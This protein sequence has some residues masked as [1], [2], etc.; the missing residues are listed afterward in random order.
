M[1]IFS[2]KSIIAIGFATIIGL[3]IALMAVWTQNVADNNRHLRKLVTKQAESRLVSMLQNRAKDR[4]ISI[5]RMTSLEDPFELEDEIT[6]FRELGSDFIKAREQLLNQLHTPL[7]ESAWHEVQPFIARGGQIQNKTVELILD[8]NLD[9]AQQLVWRELIPNQDQVMSRLENMVNLQRNSAENDLAQY[10]Q[11]NQHTYILVVFLASVAVLLGLFT[12]F[13]VRRTGK[14]EEAL[15]AQGRRIRALYEVTS[16]PGLSNEEQ[17]LE[18]LRLGSRLLN[19]SSANVTRIEAESDMAQVL[20]AVAPRDYPIQP[21]MSIPLAQS[22]AGKAF[23]L[24]KTI[25]FEDISKTEF[26]KSPT[27]HQ[28][29]MTAYL[30]APIM[31]RNRHIGVISFCSTQVRKKNFEE[32]DKDIA[33]LIAGWVGVAM[34]RDMSQQELQQAKDEAET[35]NLTKSAFLANMSHELRTPLNAIIGYSELMMDEAREEDRQQDATDLGHI[36]NSGTHLL[37]LINGVLD[38]SKI[39]AGK[40][41]LNLEHFRL[42]ELIT[43]VVQTAT[44]LMQKNDNRFEYHNNCTIDIVHSDRLKL[45]QI[46]LNL[47]SNAAKFTHQGNVSMTLSNRFINGIPWLSVK[48]RDTGIGMTDQ[49]VK[50]VFNSFTQANAMISTRYGGTGLGLSISK[51]MSL[52]LGGTMQAHSEIDHGSIFELNLPVQHDRYNVVPIERPLRA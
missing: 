6:H 5:Y 22:P 1:S 44:P 8:G 36:H 28:F 30:G 7:A 24:C 35:A 11:Q 16:L 19:M 18:M 34:E 9:A 2:S 14:T 17:I 27:H 13:V 52:I 20:F 38:L 31:V 23:H 12:I 10:A 50:Q 45:M 25:A 15:L 3:L 32:S 37:K 21:G 42:D 43:E 26:L 39:E 40:M 33:N 48:V 49:Q 47:L 4:A 46:I 41:H 51:K 29:G